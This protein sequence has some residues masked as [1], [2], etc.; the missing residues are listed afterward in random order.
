MSLSL[1]IG[2]TVC[3]PE[4]CVFDCTGG[5]VTVSPV[6]VTTSSGLATLT[7]GLAVGAP[8]KVY[9]TPQANGTLKAYML[10]YFTGQAPAQ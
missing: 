3:Q 1:R 6:D 5:I 7:T 9:G 4:V 10:A 2:R 8:V